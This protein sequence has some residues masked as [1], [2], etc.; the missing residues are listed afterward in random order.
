MHLCNLSTN[1]TA[2]SKTDFFSVEPVGGQSSGRNKTKNKLYKSTHDK[3]QCNCW[4]TSWWT[5][6]TP[7]P[8]SGPF[9]ELSP[10]YINVI[11]LVHIELLTENKRFLSHLLQHNWIWIIANWGRSLHKQCEYSDI[12]EDT[13]Q[14]QIQHNSITPSVLVFRYQTHRKPALVEKASNSPTQGGS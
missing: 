5:S 11:T 7:S 6:K 12:G 4:S 2:V 14:V 9:E 13:I 3:L 8:S 10:P 1:T